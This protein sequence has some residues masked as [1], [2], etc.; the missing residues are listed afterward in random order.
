MKKAAL[1]FATA[2]TIGVTALAPSPAQA[3]WRGGWGGWGPGLAGGLIA[4][5]VIGG[6][7]LAP[8]PMAH[9]V[10]TA[11]RVTAFMAAAMP[12][13][14]TVDTLPHTMAD[15]DRVTTL[16]PITVPGTR[17]T[18]ALGTGTVMAGD[19]RRLN[20][21]RY[22]AHCADRPLPLAAQSPEAARG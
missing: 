9:T 14:I 13:L 2:A 5:A 8:T 20:Q 19:G 17:H 12:P 7:C 6:I 1:A 16:R 21:P 11:D 22:V 3:Q 4:G 10:T 15:T 18:M